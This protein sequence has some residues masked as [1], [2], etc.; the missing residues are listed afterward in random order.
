MDDILNIA[1]QIQEKITESEQTRPLLKNLS[2]QKARAISNFAKNVAITELKLKNGLIEEWE[3]IKVGKVTAS[4]AR[5]LAEGIC[6]F[7]MNDKEEQEALYK[8]EIVNLESLRAELN[9]L[10][11]IYKHLE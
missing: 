6:W 5:K 2:R 11:S 4:S 1:K 8:A 9:G 7:E 3:G 10:Q